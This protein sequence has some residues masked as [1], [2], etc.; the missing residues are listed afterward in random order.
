MRDVKLDLALVQCTADRVGVHTCVYG[1][2][3]QPVNAVFELVLAGVAELTAT[4]HCDPIAKWS[5][6]IPLD[7]TRTE[8]APLDV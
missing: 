4:P 1:D 6:G 7:I 2:S 5:S 8:G 3:P